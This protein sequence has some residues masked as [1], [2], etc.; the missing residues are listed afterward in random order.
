MND[1]FVGKPTKHCLIANS[2]NF[3]AVSHDGY[4]IFL[5]DNKSI[6]R[7]FNFDEKLIK[8][9][10]SPRGQSLYCIDK[11][12]NVYHLL[13]TQK[14]LNKNPK[15]DHLISL[16]NISINNIKKN[17]SF[18]HIIPYEKVLYLI[19]NNFIHIIRENEII[20]SSEFDR[21]ITAV[22]SI[23]KD[24]AVS[25]EICEL[26]HPSSS[27]ILA[28]DKSGRISRISFPNKLIALPKISFPFVSKS[29]PIS[30]ISC[31]NGKILVCG[32]FGT[33]YSTIIEK[34]GILPHPISSIF[35]TNDNDLLFV[36]EKRLFV[37]SLSNPSAFQAVPSF[38]ARI[39]CSSSSFALTEAGV[40][41]PLTSQTPSN[42]NPRPQ[43][44]EYAL[45]K[46]YAIS[47]EA[48]LLKQEI[49]KAE[50]RLNDYQL[51]KALQN[52]YK[53]HKNIKSVTK[54][55][56]GENN[57]Y[58]NNSIND[59]IESNIA[60]N[61][62]ISPDGQVSSILEVQILTKGGYSC[63]GTSIAV[64]LKFTGQNSEIISLPSIQT[65]NVNWT[66]ELKIVGPSAVKVDL[67]VFHESEAICI[68]SKIFDLIDL[69]API[70]LN[71][72][73]IGKLAPMKAIVRQMDQKAPTSIQF[74]IK[75][76]IPQS[77]ID[78]KAYISPYGE[79][80]TVR[81]DSNVCFITAG[82]EATAIAARAAVLR[83]IKTEGLQTE[84]RIFNEKFDLVQNC[85]FELADAIDHSPLPT[86]EL[87]QKVTELHTFANQWIESIT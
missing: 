57:I 55:S 24:V 60:V 75:N 70:E 62:L 44:I 87:T 51:I 41:M 84:D 50:S 18:I 39:A 33:F 79:H 5:K 22:C 63:R 32:K 43:F 30:H 78:P 72:V 53:N 82:T 23:P 85:G 61:S 36:S 35:L 25:H 6:S 2:Q 73:D 67:L 16:S 80:W 9:L 69:S 54:N 40:L 83:R 7:F 81:I 12:L 27:I 20:S 77:L 1:F 21:P 15:F 4:T 86:G 47:N 59:I 74:K 31:E 56:D 58:S 19:L 13:T 65:T 17:D 29:D 71:H 26:N 68:D 11:K 38:P 34:E 3:I 49:S 46:L 28:G 64:H 66:R 10:F 52:F 8:I 14:N 76:E 48:N 45:N 37:S 42:L